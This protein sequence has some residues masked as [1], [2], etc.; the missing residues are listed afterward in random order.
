LEPTVTAALSVRDVSM[1]FGGVVALSGV[2]I[3]VHSGTIHALIGPNGAGKSTLL[4][5]LSAV[6]RPSSG[7]ILCGGQ[8]VSQLRTEQLVGLGLARTFQN[9]VLGRERTVHE[10]LMDGRHHLMTTGV[11]GMGLRLR[12]AR[13]EE[14]VHAERVAEIAEFLELDA[15]LTRPVGTLSYGVQKRVELG[16][17]LCAE[18]S[19]VIL[20]E[21]V[22]GMS[23]GETET[24]ADFIAEAR[25]ALD[26]TVLLVEHNMGFVMRLADTIS[27]L[28]FGHIIATGTP[29]SIRA[30]PQVIESY[31]G[32]PADPTGGR[33]RSLEPVLPDVGHE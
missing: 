11:I 4:N 15:V 18:P 27:V 19:I 20:D 25:S 6:Y 32:I 7:Q 33:T 10:N 30:D 5:L 13:R 12:G 28:D 14:A 22:A 17:A 24:M 3:D 1:R 9:L 2:N 26:L 8:D 31:L 29:E 23:S 16:R 21:P